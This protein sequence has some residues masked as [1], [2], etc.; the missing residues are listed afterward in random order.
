MKMQLPLDYE[1]THRFE[2]LDI[3]DAQFKRLVDTASWNGITPT[4]TRRGRGSWEIL[5]API[6]LKS[7]P[8]RR[9]HAAKLK[10][11]G[12]WNPTIPGDSAY[13]NK[14]AD[15]EGEQPV[16]PMTDLLEYL[17]TY[18]HFGI[19]ND[20]EYRFAY[21]SASPIGGI[22]HERAHREYW[23]AERLVQHGVPTIAPLCVVE[24]EGLKFQDQPMG[25]VITLSPGTAPYRISEILFGAAM[26]RGADPGF[27]AHYDRVR[28]D[29][30]VEGGP[31]D[32][33]VRLEVI[34]KLAGQAGKLLHDFSM[35]ELYR[36][37]GDWGNFVYSEEEK[38]LFLIDLDSVQDIN[39]LPET[40]RSLQVWRDI[41]SAVYRMTAKLGYP[42][43]L[44][45]YTI[46]NLLEFDPI[47]AL[48]AG[49]FSEVPETELRKV[50]GKLWC[51]FIPHMMLLN[52]HRDAILTEWDGDRRKSYK[53]DHDLFY[54]L[55][56]TLLQPLFARSPVGAKYPS[57]ITE[58]D[59]LGKAE[60][61]LGER[62]QYLRYL[63]A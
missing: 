60:R 8:S 16:P 51:Y 20:G 23:A 48:L 62:S 26:E 11:V 63:L 34:C 38:H 14:L 29:L 32:E 28:E 56:L 59:M 18:P 45:Q 6:S 33:R 15:N 31:G 10:G 7:D 1:L 27:D 44:G 5:D 17:I 37:S 22:V 42:T 13:S 52:K 36:Y 41:A 2:D 30:G 24:Y 46:D 9:F 50:S 40:V 19:S 49:Y 39:H 25:A 4:F 54:I 57:T 55:A 35:A 61:F 43:A 53:M 12:L 3:A 47:S 58:A 21:S